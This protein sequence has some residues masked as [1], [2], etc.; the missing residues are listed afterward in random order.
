MPATGAVHRIR[1]ESLAQATRRSAPGGKADEIFGKADIGPRTSAFGVRADALAYPME[2]LLVAEAVEKVRE[3][4]I[5]GTM[6]QNSV[7][8]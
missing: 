6:I 4:K 8:H 7:L 1:S 5:F 2:C 3:G